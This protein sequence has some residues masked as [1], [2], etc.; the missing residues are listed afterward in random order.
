MA[1]LTFQRDAGIL[2]LTSSEHK[3]VGVWHAHN[4]VK[5]GHQVWP[6]G[7]WPY[8]R[9]NAH[10]LLS[11]PSTVRDCWNASG[12]SEKEN[13]GI[14]CFGIYLFDVTDQSGTPIDG[15]G[16]HSGRTDAPPAGAL[17]SL[18]GKTL[19]CIRVPPAAMLAINQEH[20]GGDAIREI[21][22]EP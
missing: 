5:N 19:G 9:Y 22:V 1:K 21:T 14:G 20:F 2:I 4:K 15:L 7:T 11:S 16:V 10:T 6:T 13:P 3:I 17:Y 18:G 8:E 12:I